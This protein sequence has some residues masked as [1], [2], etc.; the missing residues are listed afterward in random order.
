[1][2]YSCDLHL[3][4]CLSPCGDDD[5]TPN[6][7]AGM[8]VLNGLEIVAL[9]DHNSC[10]NCPAFFTA[11]KR[12]G[13]VPIPGMELT[14]AEDIHL[15]CLFETLEAAMEFDREIQS[16]RLGVKNRPEIF[17]NQLILDGD[18]L[19]IGTED[20]LLINAT[21]L[22]IEAAARLA[23]AFG[24]AVFP[25]HVDREANGLLAILGAMPEEPRFS[26]VEFHDGQNIA[27]YT[28][29]FEGLSGKRTVVSSD[30]HNLWSIQEAGQMCFDL[31]VEPYSGQGVRSAVIALLRAE[32][33]EK[34]P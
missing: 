32:T 19:P 33:G 1:M 21:D 18:D 11:C 20:A 28:A 10:K 15:V 2:K 6:N 16:H 34:L 13:L 31:N 26:A 22:A 17:G 27:P 24:A 4:S 9:T 14:T 29:R 7:I 3:H 25:A 30:A 23:R 5:M 12:Q 8:A